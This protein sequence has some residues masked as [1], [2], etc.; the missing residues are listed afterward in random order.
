M[1]SFNYRG[2]HALFRGLDASERLSAEVARAYYDVLRH[3]ELVELSKDNYAAHRLIYEQIER[4]TRAGVSR[5]VDLEQAFGRLALSESN[6]LTDV[7]NLH[8]VSMR[9]QRIVGETPRRI[10]AGTRARAEPA[11]GH[12]ERHAALAYPRT[13]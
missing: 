1:R 5:G 12:R 8:D 9:Y 11:A 10:A 3:R 6:L 4:R 7:T 2:A 13:R